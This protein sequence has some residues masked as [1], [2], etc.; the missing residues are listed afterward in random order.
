[1]QKRRT[2]RERAL[3]LLY[4][5]DINAE[6][7]SMTDAE[8]TN[9][10][11]MQMEWFDQ[12]AGDTGRELAYLLITGVKQNIKPIDTHIEHASDN[13]TVRRLSI[14]DRNI[15]RI[16]VY[17]MA[18]VNDV[19]PRVAIN[20][21]IEIAKLYGTENSPKF[22]NGVLDRIYRILKSNSVDASGGNGKI[23]E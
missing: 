23:I 4:A 20:E 22:I 21:A 18:Y 16:A 19:P 1:M 14:I 9:A 17:E 8:F 10:A 5:L 13:W 7:D 12:S 2:C 3:Q 11:S 6:I 15:L